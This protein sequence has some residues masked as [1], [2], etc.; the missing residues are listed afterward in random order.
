MKIKN[1]LIIVNLLVFVLFMATF[2]LFYFSAQRLFSLKEL[3]RDTIQLRNRM[4]SLEY[5]N[6]AVLKSSDIPLYKMERAYQAL[7][8][9]LNELAANEN[10][11]YLEPETEKR[12]KLY[13]DFITTKDFETYN[14]DMVKEISTLRPRI[15]GSSIENVYLD[16]KTGQMT[17]RSLYDRIQVVRMKILEFSDWYHPFSV[18]FKQITDEVLQTVQA[19]ITWV[20]GLTG[21]ALA[22]S[23]GVSLSVIILIYR[24]M[25][26]KIRN[27]RQGIASIS[28]GNLTTRIKVDWDDELATMSENFNTLTETIWQRLNTIGS[29]IHN[30]GQ[31]LTQ[32]PDTTQLEQTILQLA[33]ENTHAENG[34]FYKVDSENQT[35]FPVH[36]TDGFAPP[37]DPQIYEQAV[38]FGKTILGIAAMTG[39]PVFV[40]EQG[41]QNLIPRRHSVERNYISS[42]IV[43][44]LISE[45]D[46][47]GIL[48]LEKNTK[49]SL[50]RDMDYSNIL[51]FIEFSAV[52]LKN[53][54]K[55]SELLKSTGLNRELQI[56]SDIQKSLLP[57]KIPKVPRFDIAVQTYTVK[58]ISGDIYDFFPVDHGRW[59]FCMAEVM[60]K[61]IASSMILVI[62]R[63]LI[64]ILVRPGQDPSE[65]LNQLLL[66]FRETTGITT[67]VQ[68]SV[69]LMEPE[70]NGF[71]YCGTEDQKMLLYSHEKK[72]TSL[73]QSPQGDDGRFLSVRGTLEDFDT[74]IL[75]TDGFYNAKNASG[76]TY[77]WNP[78]MKIVEKYSNRNSSWLQ[79]AIV[80]DVKFF[81]RETEQSDDRSMF[82]AS[83]REKGK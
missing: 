3:E 28:G 25:I 15:Y 27:V 68:I 5:A 48:C 47:I 75:M 42:C 22:I 20:L 18:Q 41:G 49:N 78:V 31:S 46:L 39:E 70:E 65:L 80:K 26:S 66:N 54:E 69:C 73:I 8:K 77:G 63:T 6:N 33:I 24:N 13:Y 60:E 45:R 11:K 35:I 14:K 36:K 82:I 79:D 57:P 74:M 19:Q 30:I 52:T 44:P 51:S 10:L 62:L 9:S 32:D 64:R 40:K 1:K 16:W 53:L 21:T 4:L 38:P 61:G 58:G 2:F 67:P 72:S 55:Y 71:I 29:I 81:E 43:M 50:F 76:N 17:D 83:F 7:S 23:L 56:A 12:I 34:A 59:L 37:Y